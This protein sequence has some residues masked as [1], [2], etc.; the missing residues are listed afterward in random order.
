LPTSAKPPVF[1]M[2]STSDIKKSIF[3]RYYVFLSN[4]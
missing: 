1:T 4:F 3:I 2:S